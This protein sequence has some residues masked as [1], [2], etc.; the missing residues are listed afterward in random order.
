MIAEIAETV[1]GGLIAALS[2]AGMLWFER[3][4]AKNDAKEEDLR[5]KAATAFAMTVKIHQMHAWSCAIK[6]KIDE[7]FANVDDPD[8]RIDPGLKVLPMLMPG[9]VPQAFSDSELSLAFSTKGSGLL[10]ALLDLASSFHADLQVVRTFNEE[11]KEYMSFVQSHAASGKFHSGD[12]AQVEISAAQ[13]LAD[14]SRILILNQLVG[15]MIQATDDRE[16]QCRLVLTRL[17]SSLK[18]L[19][20]VSVPTVTFKD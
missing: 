4:G 7:C 10:E 2:G 6:R 12:Q 3:R 19:P 18:S 15:I 8:G 9:I 13:T 11:R 14:E 16:K 20:G 5:Q 17:S 1:V